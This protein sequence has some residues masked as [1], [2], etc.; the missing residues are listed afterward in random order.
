[1]ERMNKT[2]SAEMPWCTLAGTQKGKMEIREKI[3]VLSNLYS[4]QIA[5]IP[6]TGQ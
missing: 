3:V 2:T 6:G 1:M 4:R 5:R